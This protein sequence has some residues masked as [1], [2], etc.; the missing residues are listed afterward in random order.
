MR[1][2]CFGIV[3]PASERPFFSCSWFYALYER[4]TQRARERDCANCDVVISDEWT[5]SS[6]RIA[7]VY[8]V[9]MRHF[10]QDLGTV[11]CTCELE[12]ALFSRNVSDLCSC[13]LPH[14]DYVARVKV[15]GSAHAHGLFLRT[16]FSRGG[17]WR[18]MILL[19]A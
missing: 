17:R 10:T 13:W 14:I 4:E 1:D 3:R 18:C 19:L 11:V 2:S 12:G 5:S 9:Q 15:G 16:F 6:F 7:L 8:C